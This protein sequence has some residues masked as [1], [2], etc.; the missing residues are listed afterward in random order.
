M[1]IA[2]SS[3]CVLHVSVCLCSSTSIFRPLSTNSSSMG[4]SLPATE[5][6]LPCIVLVIT[7]SK[8]IHD[9]SLIASLPA[10]GA[11]NRRGHSEAVFCAGHYQGRV[12]RSLLLSASEKWGKGTQLFS[13]VRAD[14]SN[15][16][17]ATIR[18]LSL[19]LQQVSSRLMITVY[20][21]KNKWNWDVRSCQ[22]C[23]TF[24]HNCNSCWPR[25][26]KHRHCFVRLS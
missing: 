24:L 26:L 4:A 21:N 9:L 8:F 17:L 7:D 13:P 6:F 18:V 10:E 23:S 5:V 14:N 12:S 3:V 22:Q 25:A 16:D 15:Y 1:S 2:S 19:F 11:A 20:D